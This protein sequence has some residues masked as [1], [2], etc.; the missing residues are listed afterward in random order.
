MAIDP[1]K[2]KGVQATAFAQGTS[3]NITAG[4]IEVRK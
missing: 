2:D 1:F 4:S 3:N